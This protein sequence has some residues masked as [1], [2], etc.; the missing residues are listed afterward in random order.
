MTSDPARVIHARLLTLVRACLAVAIFATSALVIDYENAGDPAF[1][2][3]ESACL[4]VRMSDLGTQIAEE[5]HKI[6]PGLKLPGLALAVLVGVVAYTFIV[7]TNLTR[8]LLAAVMAVGAGA[9]GI[10]ISAQAKLGAYCAYCMIVDSAV[11]LGAVFALAHAALGRSAPPPAKDG[12][13]PTPID[14]ATDSG[15][16]LAWGMGVAA[17]TIVPFVWARFPENP[18]L[19]KAI[20]ALQEPGK[21]VIVSFTD[22]EC[23]Y[24]RKLHTAIEE[25]SKDEDVVVKRL[26]VPLEFHRGAVPPALAYVCA[27]DDKKAVLAHAFYAAEPTSLTRPGVLEMVRTAGGDAAAIEACMNGP[28]ARRQIEQEKLL[29]FDELAGQGV[30]TTW[31][32]STLVR[33]AQSQKLLAAASR[34]GTTISLPVWGMFVVGGIALVVVL[35]H[36][37]RRLRQPPEAPAPRTAT[38][39]PKRAADSDSGAEPD[40]DSDSEES[41]DAAASEPESESDPVVEKP[42]KSKPKNK[43]KRS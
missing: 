43:R 35:G 41:A 9:A 37:E 29:F 20:E 38:Q 22:F 24:C 5:L 42:S 31:V 13:T 26:M 6:Q 4:K 36:S 28:E 11:I 23:P 19:P 25:A 34:A 21:V 33:G 15:T 1:C 7:R 27:P 14:V 32:G 8:Y 16:I 3:A 30:P 39:K 18:P 10:F 12:D 17:I 2:G 40:S